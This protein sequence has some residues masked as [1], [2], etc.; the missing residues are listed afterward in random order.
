MTELLTAVSILFVAA[1]VFL[2]VG[3][4]FGLPTP[5]L[6][7]VAGLVVGLVVPE[8]L[9]VT[10][11]EEGLTITLAQIGIA[12][13]VFTFGANIQFGAVRTVLGDSEIAALVGATVMG[14]LGVG[15]G[16]GLGLDVQQAAF[17]GVAAAL[18][19]TIVG[20]SL[21]QAD[22]RANLVHGRL[23]ESVHLVQ[24]LLAVGLLLVVSAETFAA[25]PIATQ[26]GYGVVLF[27]AALFVNRVVFGIVESLAGGSDEPLIVGVVALLVVFMGA[28]EFVGVSVVA[29]AF[30]AGLAVRRDPAEHI[31]LLNGLDSIRDFFVAV[32]FVTV[33]ALVTVP[34]AEKVAIAAVLVVL[35][36][37]VKPAVTIAVLVYQGYEARSATLT[38]LNLDQI[39]EFTLIIA[40]QASLL[41]S[42][43]EPVFEA[44]ILA[45]A[46][47]MITSTLTSRYGDRLYSLLLARNIVSGQHDKID[48]RSDVP[49]DITD[50]VVILGYGRQGHR[51][52]ET[53][54]RFDRPY[55]VIENDPAL[56]AEL[57]RTCEAYVFGDA[58]EPYTLE[59]ARVDRAQLVVST[60]EAE[61]ISRQLLR[62]ADDTDVVLRAAEAS[63]A[64]D[65]LE[66]GA[67]YASVAD[68]LAAER[69][70]DQLEAI[71]GGELSPEQLREEHLAELT[72]RRTA[73]FHTTADEIDARR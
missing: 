21:L 14:A 48:E 52:A 47:T 71:A 7:I 9:G 73:R 25:D 39:S 51:L 72:S 5:P 66:Q 62:F 12:L 57:E 22:I 15:A 43:G 27:V 40:I 68:V 69:L 30:A 37:V 45:A 61:P 31:G 4:R 44:I 23:A 55:V 24:D 35:T 54:E 42:L 33:G 49:E 60:V 8:L 34:T 16:L 1:G 32:F 20:T 58:M 6:L 70:V 17:V 64:I 11:I 29:G 63:S 56:L 50:H 67:T 53:C 28:A 65:L 36:A 46:V 41:G 13:L 38:G 19:S 10:L 59:K 26:L 3:N 2:L 18:S